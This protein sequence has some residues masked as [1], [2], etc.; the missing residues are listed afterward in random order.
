MVLKSIYSDYDSGHTTILDLNSTKL[1]GSGV[2][3]SDPA[4]VKPTITIN[5]TGK[6][7][8][9]FK[10]EPRPFYFLP[11]PMKEKSLYKLPRNLSVPLTLVCLLKL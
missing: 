8:Y 11:F 7:G 3:L 2:G 6:A 5:K 9:G 1:N 10:K 4:T